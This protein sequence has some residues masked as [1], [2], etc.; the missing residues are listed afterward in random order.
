MVHVVLVVLFARGDQAQRRRRLIGRKKPP[1]AGR[2]RARADQDE[3]L[4]AG[5][6]GEDAEHLVLLFIEQGVGRGIGSERVAVEPIRPLG[7][8]GRRVEERLVVRRPRDRR[9]AGDLLGEEL[10]RREVLD[11]E[12]VVSKPGVV[13][14]V[15]EEGAVA[16]DLSG[17]D[18]H[19]LLAL[20]Q[21][22]DVEVDLLG[23]LDAALLAAV[24]RVLLAL[25]G[26]RVVVPA[27]V[28]V[29]HRKVGFLDAPEHLVVES[30]SE[31]LGRLHE[32][33]GIRVL[34]LEERADLR[35][36]PLAHP[37]V[38]V[39]ESLVVQGLHVGHLRG[40][41][42]RRVV[43]EREARRRSGRQDDDQNQGAPVHGISSWGPGPA[44]ARQR[45][46]RSRRPLR[47][48]SSTGP[49]TCASPPGS[50]RPSAP[51]PSSRGRR[52]RRACA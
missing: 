42:G 36:V 15:G 8:V 49:G 11:P 6:K 46:W 41:R 1:L 22:V 34:G 32:G 33:V 17:A 31:G 30:L 4:A 51:R 21:G 38:V 23:R 35:V 47:S 39:L 14:R 24:D 10:A 16:A 2:M 50:A 25:L 45:P 18:R 13:R 26:A 29:G 5:E 7:W 28:A 52:P 44:P 20:G 12:R 9:D 48:S 37:E 19:E 27:A 43:G 40:R 3:G